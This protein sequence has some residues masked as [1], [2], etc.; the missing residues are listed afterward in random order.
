MPWTPAII[1][2]VFSYHI[3]D[4][5]Q[6][7]KA[8]AIRYGAKQFALVIAQLTPPGVDQDAALHDLRHVSRR[9]IE[10]LALNGRS[11]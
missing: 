6:I 2:E 1:D 3:L 9:A 7:E 4:P 8:E 10:A 11:A 5:D